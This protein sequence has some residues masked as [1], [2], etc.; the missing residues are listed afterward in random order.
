ME[1]KARTGNRG[2]QWQRSQYPSWAFGTD[3][4]KQAFSDR[5]AASPPASTTG[6]RNRSGR[7]CNANSSTSELGGAETNWDRRLF[8]WI[9]AWYNP[10][11]R[12]SGIGDLSPI[13]Y[14]NA[15]HAA[16]AA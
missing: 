11:R 4:V 8:E 9:E 7:P 10:T 6:S 15:H 1:M 14:E 5:W 12:H 2:A 16:I 13:D 3:S